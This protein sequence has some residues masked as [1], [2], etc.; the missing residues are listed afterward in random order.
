M[1]FYNLLTT[2]AS[3]PSSFE[4]ENQIREIVASE[5]KTLASEVATDGFG[6]LYAHRP[7][8]KKGHI[9]FC[10]HLDK[11]MGSPVGH[12]DRFTKNWRIG[13]KKMDPQEFQE[14]NDE[15]L[16]YLKN[17]SQYHVLEP[18]L[19]RNEIRIKNKNIELITQD[20]EDQLEQRKKLYVYA[21]SKCLINNKFI[22]GK[23][24]DALG[25][26][27]IIDLFKNTSAKDTP[28]ISG[29]FTLGE[30]CGC[31]GAS[32]AVTE[33]LFKKY[34]PNKIIVLDTSGLQEPGTGIVLYENCGKTRRF[35]VN[36]EDIS[37]YDWKFTK[38][39]Y[40]QYLAQSYLRK[41]VKEQ[42][43][44]QM[45][46][47]AKQGGYKL[48]TRDAVT[49]DSRVF[50]EE[51]SIPTLA[52]EVPVKNIHSRVETCSIDDIELMRKF[53]SDYLRNS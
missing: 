21:L 31:L 40:C 42:H 36:F 18:Y 16:L 39:S 14:A 44:L 7:G 49:N 17:V 2:I 30:E 46:D 9:M 5:M 35:A 25:V 3:T 23:M 43:I 13:P 8:K 26:S 37:E 20:A 41:P 34:N 28:T 24:D 45:E 50:G 51:T 19:D 47:F 48:T 33:K 6:N 29:L 27:L 12:F 53:L 52:L 32:A 10:A 4:A 1:S 38:E 22:H 11:I 15:F